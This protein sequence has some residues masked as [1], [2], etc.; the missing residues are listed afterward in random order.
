MIGQIPVVAAAINMGFTTSS[1]LVQVVE[2]DTLK[3][4]IQHGGLVYL[5]AV[6]VVAYVAAVVGGTNHATHSADAARAV[7]VSVLLL[8]LVSL[9]AMTTPGNAEA[10]EPRFIFMFAGLFS[11]MAA[12]L[13]ATSVVAQASSVYVTF[14]TLFDAFLAALLALSDYALLRQFDNDVEKQKPGVSTEPDGGENAALADRIQTSDS[15]E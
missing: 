7:A 9:A 3:D 12:L 5:N 10:R 13:Y 1:A 8:H 2:D 6:L 11:S 14:G 15:E 4:K